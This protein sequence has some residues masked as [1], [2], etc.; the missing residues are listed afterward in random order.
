MGGL[1]MEINLISKKDKTAVIELTD[2]KETFIYPLVD[3]L[4]DDKDV[5]L[6]AYKTGHPQLDRPTLTVK[7]DRV[8]PE[9]AVKKA[10]ENL[11]DEIAVLKKEFEKAL[12]KPAKKAVVKKARA[13]KKKELPK[14]KK[15]SAAAKTK[16]ETKPKKTAKKPSK[17]GKSKKK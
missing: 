17:S 10:A 3:R 15:I 13:K 1:A 8:K 6:A 5:N 14:T 9:T 7:T 12:K 16:K 11:A 4:M 2:V